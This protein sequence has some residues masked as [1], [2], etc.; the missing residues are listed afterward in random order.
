M[1]E[2]TLQHCKGCKQQTPPYPEVT[3]D[4]NAIHNWL[5]HLG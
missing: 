1:Q 5:G 3:V 4:E 2:K